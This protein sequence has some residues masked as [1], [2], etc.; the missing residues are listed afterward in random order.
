MSLVV[1]LNMMIRI[2]MDTVMIQIIAQ[3]TIWEMILN[4]IS[5]TTMIKL[6]KVYGNLMVD[7]MAVNEKLIDRGTRIISQLT[8]LDY[9][10]SKERLISSEYSVKVAIVMEIQNCSIDE[11]HERL[12]QADGFLNRIID[13]FRRKTHFLIKASRPG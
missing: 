4:M 12:D 10:R 7:L 8:G 3:V 9:D 6:G 11:A 5:T 1:I 13:M 2:M